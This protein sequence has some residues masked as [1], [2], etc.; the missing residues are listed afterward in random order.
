VKT[1]EFLKY[2]VSV[3]RAALHATYNSRNAW[4]TVRVYEGK[5]RTKDRF[6]AG[7]EPTLTWQERDGSSWRWETVLQFISGEQRRPHGGAR[8]AGWSTR[9]GRGS[10]RWGVGEHNTTQAC[11]QCRLS[12]L[13]CQWRGWDRAGTGQGS[14]CQ[15]VQLTLCLESPIL[16]PPRLV[17]WSASARDAGEVTIDGDQTPA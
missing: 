13:A 5:L 16:A 7:S 1:R 3:N 11:S 10:T 8:E 17:Q 9:I 6:I 2:A 12:R 4:A 14:R 15:E